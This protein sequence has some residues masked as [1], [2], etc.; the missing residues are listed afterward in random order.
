MIIKVE[1][2]TIIN[3]YSK[4][5]NK[6][7]NQRG[8]VM[9]HNKSLD[10]LIKAIKE[11]RLV[12]FIGAGVSVNSGYPTW[13]S[14]VDLM[15]KRMEL[16]DVSSIPNYLQIVPEYM[17]LQDSTVYHD[18][19][20]KCFADRKN[21]NNDILDALLE[22]NPAHI[23]TTNYDNLIEHALMKAYKQG[24]CKEYQ[25]IACDEHLIKANKEHFY[26]KMHGDVENFTALVLKESDYLSYSQKHVL[27]EM[28]IKSL[29]V[30]HVFLFV[31]YGMQDSTLNTIMTWVDDLIRS[32]HTDNL[33]PIQHYFLSTDE[34]DDYFKNYFRKKRIEIL[35]P[36]IIR[37]KEKCPKHFLTDPKGILLFRM[38]HS[39]KQYQQ[40][41]SFTITS[42]EAAER[43]QYFEKLSFVSFNDVQKALNPL[44][45]YGVNQDTYG[46]LYVESH[47]NNRH[48]AYEFLT[49]E[50]KLRQLFRHILKKAGVCR[51]V[52]IND[53]EEKVV[54]LDKSDKDSIYK[55][56]VTFDFEGLYR[57]AIDKKN[58]LKPEIDAVY[59]AYVMDLK[60]KKRRKQLR[61]YIEQAGQ[62]QEYIK[63]VIYEFN[64]F[65]DG[66][67][68]ESFS[69]KRRLDLMPKLYRLPLN[70]FEQY[71]SNLPNN[72]LK[73]QHVLLEKLRKATTYS[74]TI[75]QY[76]TDR[77][78]EYMNCQIE[79][80][81]LY[82]YLI[83]N[84]IYVI[85]FSGVKYAGHAFREYI[86]IYVEYLLVSQC[87][88]VRQHE[89]YDFLNT[90]VHNNE[91]IDRLRILDFHFLLYYI[92]AKDLDVMLKRYDIH[93]L[94]YDDDVPDYLIQCLKN[95]YGALMKKEFSLDL[96]RNTNDLL[97]NLCKCFYLVT[98]IDTQ[99]QNIMQYLWEI[100]KMLFQHMDE[101]YYHV[102]MKSYQAVWNCYCDLLDSDERYHTMAGENI[103]QI[104]DN[105]YEFEDSFPYYWTFV[106]E[107]RILSNLSYCAQKTE[108]AFPAK[109][110]D[111]FIDFVT[112]NISPKKDQL[113]M[114]SQLYPL[115]NN[116]QKKRL[117][118]LYMA[119]EKKLT[120][121]EIYSLVMEDVKEW[122]KKLS[123]RMQQEC[124]KFIKR[125]QKQRQKE[126]KDAEMN[127][128]QLEKLDEDWLNRESLVSNPFIMLYNLYL[129]NKVENLT[130]FEEFIITNFWKWFTNPL[131]YDYHKFDVTWCGILKHLKLFECLSE[132]QKKVLQER[133][134]PYRKPQQYPEIFAFYCEHYL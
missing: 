107:W 77:N 70:L 99:K 16:Q 61:K 11:D 12:L 8:E 76:L 72:I 32:Y 36:K 95:I 18:M 34:P 102:C 49:G 75:T 55:K 31:G 58:K 127:G 38:I 133:L 134:E 6:L 113:S 89:R 110:I 39:C 48:K 4:T 23:I 62:K 68:M 129:N 7:L 24:I 19:L 53:E 106:L 21:M 50:K 73:I 111:N 79:T 60:R 65:S 43:L 112:Q 56:I 42:V 52:F 82:H 78:I 124:S 119:R 20:Q 64:S 66:F 47:G 131:E 46:T 83:S 86:S 63:K 100:L 29:L 123:N 121:Y 74:N 90:K 117:I 41:D 118:A 98:F 97:P 103:S 115:M 30:N 15:A 81:Q 87:E 13:P 22:W 27:I 57:G 80:E 85:N 125:L 132:K 91:T 17:F 33:E 93:T 45:A 44:F 130:E 96:L 10:G 94:C 71:F 122:D 14:L 2:D 1:N 92:A 101:F 116:T 26:I 54:E 88:I 67:H 69:Y 126:Q 3:I 37:P 109:V 5:E 108:S 59:C 40:T 105:F 51:I 35:S 84:R 128:Y 28:V 104:L 114:L 120:A 25:M 9:K